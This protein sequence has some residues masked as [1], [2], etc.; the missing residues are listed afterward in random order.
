M[1]R[2]LA[3]KETTAEVELV[4]GLAVIDD[5]EGALAA[6]PLTAEAVVAVVGLGY[7]GL[8]TAVALRNAG[9]RVIG[10]DS[11]ERRLQAIRGG[12]AELLDSEREDLTRHL[13]EEAFVLT[14]S[15]TQS[16]WPISC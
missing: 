15:P 16:A 14:S 8:P 2:E 10:I 1:T 11:S 3:L 9:A 13:T 6:E 12:E 5:L 7:V 4:E